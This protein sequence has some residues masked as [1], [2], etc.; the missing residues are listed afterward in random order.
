MAKLAGDPSTS[1]F[2]GWYVVAAVFFVSAVAIGTRQA[3]GLFV[4][5]WAEEFGVSVVVISAVSSAGWVVNGLAQPVVGRLTDRFGGRVVM[6]TGMAVLGSATLLLAASPNIWVLAFLHV[7]VISFAISGVMFTPST[8]LIARWFRRRRGTA[9]GIVTSGGSIGGIVLVPLLAY[10]LI[11]G[12]WRV[13]FVAVGAVMLAGALPVLLFVIRDNPE[14][15]GLEPDG[16]GADARLD[17]SQAGGQRRGPLTADRWPQC[18]R[19]APLWLLGTSYVVCG[20]TTAMVGTHYI[21]FATSEG[22]STGVAALAFALLSFL[23]LVGVLGAG[24]L[25]DRMPRKNILATV[26]WVRGI[27]FVLLAVLP[28]GIGIWAFAVVAGISWL[29][30]VPLTSALASEIYGVK[31]IG[32]IVGLLTM[33]HQLGGAAAVLLAG[34]SFAVLGS[35]TPA[36]AGSAALLV[37]AGTASYMVRERTVS[38]RYAGAPLAAG[39]EAGD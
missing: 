25:S 19:S 12:G 3:F 4:G 9:M 26:Y 22:I 8:A 27:G 11:L 5:P 1:R 36:F 13:T 14:D 6:S 15:L 16:G 33:V 34:V 20:V 29:A 18:F 30:T 7:V 35:Y 23:N 10:L 28:A 37:A 24:W 17:L 21:P 2:Y 38:V 32:I 31:N 39:A